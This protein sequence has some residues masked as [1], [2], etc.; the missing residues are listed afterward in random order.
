LDN[1]NQ[2]HE[3]RQLLENSLEIYTQ[4]P[5]PAHSD[6]AQTLN[7]LGAVLLKLGEVEQAKSFFEQAKDIWQKELGKDH[8]HSAIAITNLGSIYWK[9][10]NID[11]AKENF[12]EAVELYEKSNG[13]GHPRTATAYNNLGATL[14]EAGDYQ[15][16]QD[17]LQKALDVFQMIELDSLNEANVRRHLGQLYEKINQPDQAKK[18]YRIALNILTNWEEKTSSEHPLTKLI[19]ALLDPLEPLDI[20]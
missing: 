7:N 17:Y 9:Q 3:A 10:G 11:L 16:A 13:S 12:K 2:L 14:R 15:D 1:L 4:L 19:L 18:H 8:P 20:D 6:R 5:G